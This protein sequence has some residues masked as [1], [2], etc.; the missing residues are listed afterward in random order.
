MHILT[1]LCLSAL[2]KEDGKCFLVLKTRGIVSSF[3]LI[4]EAKLL[5]ILDKL[6]AIHCN[7]DVCFSEYKGNLFCLSNFL[8]TCT[9]NYKN[10][11]FTSFSLTDFYGTLANDKSFSDDC[12]Q[13]LGS[14]RTNKIQQVQYF[15]S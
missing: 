13:L 4:K 6:I 10:K 5:P 15:G 3:Y 8:K 14:C 11:S 2:V 12:R 9:K 7:Y 1:L